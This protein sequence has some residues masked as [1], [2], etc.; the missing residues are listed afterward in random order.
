MGENLNLY[1][2]Y[3]KEIEE[4]ELKGLSPKPIDEGDLLAVIIDQIMDLDNKHRKVS[5]DFFFYNVLPGTTSA[6][7]V[8][9]HFLK[10]IILGESTV[11]EIS[12]DFALS[13]IHI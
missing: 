4:R 6:A 12:S 1:R 8:K 5:L 7:G 10:A 2:T 3:I 13:L 11:D 9:A